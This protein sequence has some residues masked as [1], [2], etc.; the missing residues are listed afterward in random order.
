M[1]LERFL[2]LM[3]ALEPHDVSVAVAVLELIR[4]ADDSGS[5]SRD[6][7]V[8]SVRRQYEELKLHQNA[9]WRERGGELG[10]YLEDQ[11]IGRLEAV[12]IAARD[13]RDGTWE[14]LAFDAGLWGELAGERDSM[15]EKIEAMAVVLQHKFGV[16]ASESPDNG[17]S[18]PDSRLM[19]GGSPRATAA[20]RWSTTWTWPWNR[21]RSSDCW[22]PT[23]PERPRPST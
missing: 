6:A 10:G 14:R 20:A 13:P 2:E 16:L 15:V 18:A 9:S 19:G 1:T 21:A 4:G 17:A 12:A 8:A 3:R 5:V 7:W 22:A 11:V 23:A